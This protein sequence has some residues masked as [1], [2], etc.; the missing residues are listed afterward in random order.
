MI[1]S[2]AY[3]ALFTFFDD[4]GEASG[5]GLPF[6]EIALE[7]SFLLTSQLLLLPYSVDI[8]FYGK[9]HKDDGNEKDCSFLV[10]TDMLMLEECQ[11]IFSQ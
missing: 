3:D 11:L 5:R 10:K 6:L 4:L 8:H 2:H 1:G 7:C 9:H